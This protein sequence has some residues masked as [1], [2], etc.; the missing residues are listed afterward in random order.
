MTDANKA[1]VRLRLGSESARLET[2][3]FKRLHPVQRLGI[4]VKNLIDDPRL[5]LAF[6]L[7]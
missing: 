5:D 2:L 3:N 1:L 4:V 7:E 6:F